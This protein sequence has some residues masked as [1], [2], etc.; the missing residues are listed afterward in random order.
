MFGRGYYGGE[1]SGDNGV[2][3]LLELR[4]DQTV[5]SGILKGY[6][7]YGFIDRGTV[8]DTGYGKD[9]LTLSSAGTGVRLHLAAELEADAGIAFPLDYR[10]IDN[11]S[12]HPHVYFSLVKAFKL[13]PDR[14]RMGCS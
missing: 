6:Q 11:E 13:C 3:A 2:A 14:L 5:K 7:L 8:W 1:I 9:T 12:R 4:L 10:A